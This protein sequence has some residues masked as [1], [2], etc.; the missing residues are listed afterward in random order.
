LNQLDREHQNL[1]VVIVHSH[2]REEDVQGRDYDVSG[3]LSVELLSEYLRDPEDRPANNYMFYV[4][5]PPPMMESLLP[6]LTAW[7]VP[8]AHIHTEA[9]GPASV[10]ARGKTRPES[11]PQHA[12]TQ[13]LRITFAKTGKE[14]TWSERFSNLLEFAAEHGVEISSACCAGG[15]GTCQIAVKSGDVAYDV[16]PDCEI[17][18]GCCLTCVGRPVGDLILD[19]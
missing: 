17:E 3:Y 9:F 16:A 18:D 11:E 12:P 1:H 5:G 2:P 13:K 4:C 14:L 19:A 15:C 8:K 10:K 6:Q 7:G